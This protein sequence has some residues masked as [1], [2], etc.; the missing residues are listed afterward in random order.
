MTAATAATAA[1]AR[2]VVT[3]MRRSAT[4]VS[5]HLVI[6]LGRIRSQTGPDTGRGSR[7]GGTVAITGPQL[8][9]R[10]KSSML[11]LLVMGLTSLV[12]P[13]KPVTNQV[14]THPNPCGQRRT[15]PDTACGLTCG[16]RTSCYRGG[17][18]RSAWHARGQRFEPA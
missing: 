9:K 12:R 1:T 5:C 8:R 4:T 11:A 14:T 10:V 6:T 3:L 15:Q 16:C 13:G 17:R 18:N 7:A 2:A